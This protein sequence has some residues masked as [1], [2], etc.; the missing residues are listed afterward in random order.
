M[1]HGCYIEEFIAIPICFYSTG[2]NINLDAC[3]YPHIRFGEEVQASH[4]DFRDES[5]DYPSS[6]VVALFRSAATSKDWKPSAFGQHKGIV[7]SLL[8]PEGQ[9][10]MVQR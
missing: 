1:T 7:G 4:F 6:P 5:G 10:S 9:S 3:V 8:G 2:G